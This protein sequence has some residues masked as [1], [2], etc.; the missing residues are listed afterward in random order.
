MTGYDR[1]GIIIVDYNVSNLNILYNCVV[2]YGRIISCVRSYYNFGI[3]VYTRLQKWAICN[4]N[5]P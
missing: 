3:N 4:L 2:L 5:I 1:N